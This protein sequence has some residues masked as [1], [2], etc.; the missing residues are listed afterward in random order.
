MGTRSTLTSDGRP[1]PTL[2]ERSTPTSDERSTPPRAR[3]TPTLEEPS[4]PTW[5][6]RPTLARVDEKLEVYERKL[7]VHKEG[8]YKHTKYRQKLEQLQYIFGLEALNH[9]DT[10]IQSKIRRLVRKH[11]KELRK[12]KNQSVGYS[13]RQDG[14]PLLAKLKVPQ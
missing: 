7:H 3:P 9:P 11:Q 12:L 10:V 13:G 5:S 14:A 1:T 6:E 4:T 2:E 8:S